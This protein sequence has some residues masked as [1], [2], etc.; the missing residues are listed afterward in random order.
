MNDRKRYL[1]MMICVVVV[2][3]LAALMTGCRSSGEEDF[4]ERA[5]NEEKVLRAMIE[6]PG[7]GLYQP[8]V[9]VIG[10]GVEDPSEEEIAA[11]EQKAEEEKQAW[12]SAV[13][14][15][16][17]DGMFDTFYSKWYRT[18]VIGIAYSADLTT[19]MTGFSVEDDDSTDNIEHV[20]TA[21]LFSDE[22]GNSMSFDM[23][24][25]VKADRADGNLLQSIELID[26]GG[27]WDTIAHYSDDL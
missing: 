1:L 19:T 6:Y 7:D 12:R 8:S 9:T 11:A 18:Y 2:F 22:Y 15:C 5:V 21:I 20:I 24:W 10:E 23:D 13:G 16:F 27:L 3:S 17:A 4:S 26:D 25:R 14:D